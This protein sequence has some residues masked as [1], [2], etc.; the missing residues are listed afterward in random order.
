[1]TSLSVVL[2]ATSTLAAMTAKTFMT[3][4]STEKGHLRDLPQ[5]VRGHLP[6]QDHLRLPPVM[7]GALGAFFLP[8]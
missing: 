5:Q 4:L 6:L 7:L 1:M 2:M 8:P 3:H